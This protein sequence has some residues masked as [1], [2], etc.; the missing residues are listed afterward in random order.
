MGQSSDKIRKKEFVIN[1]PVH[2]RPILTD[3]RYRNEGQD[4]AVVIFSHGFK[5]FKDW[6]HFNLVAD[7]F[8][9][10]GFIFIKFNF[11][12]NGSTLQSP[13]HFEDLEAF[14]N[15]NL[16]LEL[17]DLATVTDWVESNDELSSVH[18]KGEI[19][20]MGHSRGGGISIIRASEDKRIRKLVTWSSVG[21]YNRYLQI[22]PKEE[23]QRDGVVYISNARTKQSMPMYYQFLEDFLKNKKRY[24][25]SSCASKLT[26]PTMFIHGTND[27][28]VPFDDAKQL[29][30]SCKNSVLLKIEGGTHTFGATHPHTGESLPPIAEKVIDESICFFRSKGKSSI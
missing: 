19:Y 5:G 20:L 22:K 28:A 21:S 8:A 3:I 15:N 27:E 11:S 7:R 14:G 10:A 9:E 18:K 26:I 13:Q 16:S 29:H 24:H 4:K 25:V 12:H 2:S 6:G 17:S 1:S 23:W 30:N